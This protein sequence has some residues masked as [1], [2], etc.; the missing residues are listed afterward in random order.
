MSRSVAIERVRI[1]RTLAETLLMEA[2]PQRWDHTV[3]VAERATRITHAVGPGECEILLITAWL[4]D[5]G[6]SPQLRRTGLPALDGATYLDE[7]GWPARVAALIAHHSGA[8]FIASQH[9]LQDAL[10]RYPHE[11]SPL[12]DA[13][14]YADQTTGPGGERLDIVDRMA[15]TLNRHGP[16]SAHARAQ[17]ERGPYLLSVAARVEQRLTGDSS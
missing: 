14:T 7:H 11:Q 2:L 10:N 5:I 16:D 9:G 4:H 17:S 3:G 6:H 1:A 13:L 8:D 15:D 12:A